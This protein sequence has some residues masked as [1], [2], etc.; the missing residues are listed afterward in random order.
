MHYT[1][2]QSRILLVDDSRLSRTALAVWLAEAGHRDLLEAG[3]ASQ[4][5]ELLDAHESDLNKQ[6]G[7]VDLVLLDIVLPD[8]DGLRVCQILSDAEKLADIP[9]IIITANQDPNTLG[10]A[11]QAGAMDFLTKPIKK[12]ELLARV[13]S[14]LELKNE[15]DRRKAKEAELLRANREMGRLNEELRRL[16]NLDGLTGAPNR[17]YFDQQLQ[18]EWRRCRRANRQLAIIMVDIDHFKAYN[19]HYGHL[20]GD[21]C[22]RQVAQAMQNSLQRPGDLLARYGG[23]EFVALLPETDLEGALRTAERL[24]L[25]VRAL[26]LPH[27][28]SSSGVLV[29]VSLGVA[30]GRPISLAGPEALLGLADQ[31]LYQA[32]AQGRDR[33]RTPTGSTAA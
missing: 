10:Q 8:M 21:A 32:K 23:E 3:S 20:T 6:G 31:A 9:V 2:G 4:A 18:A 15:R 28:A 11:F 19:D 29:S 5:L 1:P 7:G 12:I 33:I 24:R 14:A 22:L 25:A 26:G 17:R 16:S 27:P 13:R 30:A